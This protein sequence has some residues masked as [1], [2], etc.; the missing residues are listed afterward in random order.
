MGVQSKVGAIEEIYNLD[1][2]QAET[3]YTTI[4][5]ETAQNI[6]TFNPELLESQTDVVENA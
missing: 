2:E 5:E 3:K 4:Q 6:A 1:N